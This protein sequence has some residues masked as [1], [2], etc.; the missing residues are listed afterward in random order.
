MLSCPVQI[1]LYKAFLL[2][3]KNKDIFFF[4]KNNYWC[5]ETYTVIYSVNCGHYVIVSM[6]F[7]LTMLISSILIHADIQ[8]V[9][10]VCICHCNW[11]K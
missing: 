7:I 11:Q 3:P 6:F 5:G 2:L 8:C 10:L 4:V 1:T 9:V